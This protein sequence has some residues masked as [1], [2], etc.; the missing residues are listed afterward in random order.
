[1]HRF[2]PIVAAQ[3]LMTIVIGL[4]MLLPAIVDF[5]LDSP[6]KYVFP[7]SSGIVIMIGIVLVLATFSNQRQKM[8]GKFAFLLTVLS[9]M[10]LPA[11]STIPFI[12]A[13]V[14]L[15]FTDAYFETVS[16]I[17]TTGSTILDNLDETDAG[18]LLWRSL[19]Q[20]FGGI[21]IIVMAI[22]ILP[23]LQIGGLNLFRMEFSDNMEKTLPRA[24]QL[25][26]WI[27]VFYVSLSVICALLYG[28]VGNMSAF[29]A[30]NHA[31]T[32][33]A[34]GGYSTHNESIGYFDNVNVEIISIIFMICGSLPFVIYLKVL[35]LNK[36]DAFLKEQQIRWFFMLLGIFTFVMTF[37]LWIG[38]EESRTLLASFRLT[39]FNIT[40]IMTGTGYASDN[41]VIWSAGA[42]MPLFFVIM[43]IGGCAGSTTCGLKM[44]RTIV[45]VQ[46]VKLQMKQMMQP[47]GIFLPYYNG[48]PLPQYINE[49]VMAFFFLY[50][51]TFAVLAIL[52]S[53]TG[54]DFITAISSSATAIAN[55][56]PG[57]GDIVGPS[58]NFSS[59][60]D[61]AKWL[62]IFGMLLG[63]LEFFTLLVLFSKSFW[64]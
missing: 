38:S 42:A 28:L 59:L 40:S 43:F 50:I 54:L 61:T 35:L 56:G 46:S 17:T 1:M 45:L 47:H 4:I 23:L 6:D 48:R 20:W 8:S 32:T 51:M 58:G 33:V 30:I 13:S 52:L 2:R 36:Y 11:F 21:G 19:L 63:R 24:T 27:S 5:Y 18:I 60:S 22:A 49:S 25:V 41:Y 26:M 31:M 3:G 64:K 53:F 44:F 7:I 10:T 37:N 15:S 14:D 29:D 12:V 9:W 34:T 57:L 62:M 39:I 16:A 55:V